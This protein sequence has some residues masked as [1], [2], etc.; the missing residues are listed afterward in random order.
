MRLKFL[1]LLIIT[2][3]YG[4]KAWGT[5][6]EYWIIESPSALVIYNNYQHRL[7]KK[8]KSLLPDF[9]AWRII[10]KDHILSDQFTHTIKAEHNRKIYFL[11]LSVE[12]ELVNTSR[13][14]QIH[15]LKNAQV[16]GDT[17]RIKNSGRLSLHTGDNRLNLSKG[18][19]IQRIFLH[20]NKTFAREIAGKISGWVEGNGPAHWEIYLPDNSDQALEKQLFFRIDQI[21]KSYNTRLD[22]LFAHLNKLYDKSIIS[23]QWR[24]EESPSFVKYTIEPREYIN[25]FADSQSYL[26]QELNDLLYGSAYH[27]HSEAGLIVVSKSPR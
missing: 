9:S 7:T 8:D 3:S 15:K 10:E 13:A 21:F 22:K 24:T 14:G 27:L 16:Q 4:Q 18:V 19:L 2:F 11:Q 17:V 23:P 20:R 25:R 1:L 6:A 12:G 26:I 5:K